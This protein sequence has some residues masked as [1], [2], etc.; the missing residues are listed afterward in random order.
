MGL[1]VN[2]KEKIQTI[3]VGIRR[4]QSDFLDEYPVD[5]HAITR[6]ALDEQIEKIDPEYL[7][8]Q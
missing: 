2:P 1:K 7:E 3:S 8:K 6:K 5:I 4:R